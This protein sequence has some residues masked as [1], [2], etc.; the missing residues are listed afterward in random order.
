MGYLEVRAGDA[1]VLKG[2]D[3]GGVDEHAALITRCHSSTIPIGTEK[4]VI[5]VVVARDTRNETLISQVPVFATR[6]AAEHHR[7]ELLETKRNIT[8]GLV[9]FLR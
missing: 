1:V 8:M 3:I 2:L 9:A 6:A 7:A 4:A 5:D